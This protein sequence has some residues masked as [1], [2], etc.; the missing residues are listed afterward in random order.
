MVVPWCLTMLVALCAFLVDLNSLCFVIMACFGLFCELLD[1]PSLVAAPSAASDTKSVIHRRLCHLHDDGIRRLAAMKI[2]GM[3]QG[4]MFQPLQFCRCCSLAKS[5]AADI[6]RQSTRDHDPPTC[7]YM[8][9]IDLWGPVD[10]AAIG[11][12]KYVLGSIDYLSG[13]HLAELLRTKDEDASAWR[14]MLLQI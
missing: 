6:C 12:Y 13:Y 3:P 7:F 9:A 5:T 4:G 14:R 8:M 2:P 1:A 10:K 11:G